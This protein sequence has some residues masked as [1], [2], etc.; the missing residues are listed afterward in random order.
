MMR[1]RGLLILGGVLVVLLAVFVAK[2]ISMQS[3]TPQRESLL[4]VDPE[5]VTKL[6]IT[7][8]GEVT[9]LERRDGRWHLT[10]PVDYPADE[11]LVESTL[12]AATTLKGKGLATS[13]PDKAEQ[14]EVDPAHGVRVALY[15]TSDGKPAAQYTVGKLAPGF[16]DTF[17]MIGDGPE[18]YQV[19]GALRYQLVRTATAW[20]D[21]TVLNFDPSAVE[22]VVF[23]GPATAAVERDGE[24]WHWAKTGTG[25]APEGD[26]SAGAVNGLLTYLGALTAHDFVDTPP[27]RKGSPPL[28]IS[29][30]GPWEEPLE[31]VVEEDRNTLYRVSVSTGGQQYLLPKDRLEKWVTDPLTALTATAE[32]M[33]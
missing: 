33:S 2:Q 20:R 12:K 25:G 18:V 9:A 21:K 3:G 7:A 23:A 6:K 24:G 1:A 28:T 5:H 4:S 15:L 29:L 26:L 11:R 30:E 17:V 13:S 14:F 8:A 31:L 10:V 27:E 22:R 32:P 16:A 19:E